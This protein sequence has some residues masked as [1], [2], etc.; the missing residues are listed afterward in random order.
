MVKFLRIGSA[1]NARFMGL[2][3]LILSFSIFGVLA[4]R[5]LILGEDW[6]FV[7]KKEFQPH[8]TVMHFCIAA[9]ESFE[10]CGTNNIYFFICLN[11]IEGFDIKSVP[12]FCQY[13][14]PQKKKK[15]IVNILI[16]KLWC[17][18]SSTQPE[19]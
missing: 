4:C 17:F 11:I 3:G 8:D 16:G 14:V 1:D 7:I 18:N 5:I 12:K 19:N 10:E 15:K 9:F 2:W 13:F 6:N